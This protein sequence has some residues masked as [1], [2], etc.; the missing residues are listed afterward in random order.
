MISV[1]KS[2]EKP[3]SL[4]TTNK[5]NGEDVVRQLHEDQHEKCYLC[6]RKCITDYEVEHWH[7]QNNTPA[8]R[9][10]WNNLFLACRYCNGKKS[11]LFDDILNP[12]RSDVEEM[13]SQTISYKENKAVFCS[14][15]ESTGVS[16]TIELLNLIFNGREG[17]RKLKEKRFFDYFIAEMNKFNKA[18]TDYMM[19]PT[20][21]NQLAVT[22]LLGIDQ[23]FL[24]FKYWAVKENAIL[25]KA[26]GSFC[27]W[28]RDK[29]A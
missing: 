15:V 12:A 25:N 26:F 5:Y 11:N 8:E 2:T 23:E 19:D 7:S 3:L 29:H 27:A 24:G 20:T 17:C 14:M 16:K 13:I 22:E 1:F 10:D 18:A 4:I 9:N 6:E 28:N 21:E